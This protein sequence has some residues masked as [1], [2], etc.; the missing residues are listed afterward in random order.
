MQKTK[1]S[2]FCFVVFLSGQYRQMLNPFSLL[3]LGHFQLSYDVTG[4]TVDSSKQR[5]GFFCQGSAHKEVPLQVCSLV[6]KIAAFLLWPSIFSLFKSVTTQKTKVF[7]Y[8]SP[9]PTSKTI[10]APVKSAEAHTVS[11]GSSA[12][13]END[14]EAPVRSNPT[15]AKM[16]EVTS[17]LRDFSRKRSPCIHTSQP[18]NTFF[19]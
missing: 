1:A 19:D 14:S 6:L 11:E 15:G 12:C 5:R 9:K 18:I 3:V 17:N 7:C 4:T 8:Q 16:I 10:K 2:S 13:D